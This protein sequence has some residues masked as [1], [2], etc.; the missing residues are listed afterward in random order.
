MGKVWR[1][2]GLWLL[3]F[4]F[5]VAGNSA[6]HLGTLALPVEPAP[7]LVV[8]SAPL[9]AETRERGFEAASGPGPAFP[10]T[11]V[12][13]PLPEKSGPSTVMPMAS[14]SGP[15]VGWPVA[16]PLTQRF[17]CS[18]YYTGR[19]GVSCPVDTPWFHEGLDFG[20]VA[21]TPVRAALTG[22]VIA[23]GPDDHG[24][25]C[26]G[27]YRGYGLLV[28]VDNG[29]G[30]QTWY[31]HLAQVAVKTGQSVT[32]DTVIGA[33]DDTG[34]ASGPHLHFGLRHKGVWVNPEAKDEG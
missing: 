17:G 16:G 33:A 1:E 12:H 20:V 10:Q 19:R 29:A 34:C 4:I 15:L 13:T 11:L 22:T 14:V 2:L 25:A 26:R 18:P 6:A 3:G 23:A 21:G 5:I 31:A 30:W 9:A 7:L 28:V 24:P 8:R 27:G 32:P